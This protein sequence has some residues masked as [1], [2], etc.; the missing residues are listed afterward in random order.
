MTITAL[1]QPIIVT[2]VIVFMA[3]AVI[4]MA[5]P[6]HKR[7]WSKTDDEEAVR[8]ALRSTRPGMYTVPNST[9]RAQFDDPKFQEKL[10]EGPQAFI[11]V[12]PSEKPQMGG[13]LL[14]MFVYNLLVA[15]LCAYFVS[16]TMTPESDY[17]SV[18][19]ISGTTAFVA[20]GMAYVQESIWFGRQWSAT[21]K[22]FLDAL[23]Y[24]LITGGVFGWLV[25]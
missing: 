3:G 7:D 20:Y 24:A 2:A 1:W 18:F 14:L 5:M 12:I 23:I 11:T 21:V 9:D 13:K 4:W 10:T 19:R 25:V 22:T 17:M 15:V 8:E 6:W 16:R